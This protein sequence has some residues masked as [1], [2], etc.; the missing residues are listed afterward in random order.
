MAKPIDVDIA[1]T[2]LRA[3][4]ELRVHLSAFRGQQYLH[5]RR[6]YLDG[7]V[8]RPGKGLAVRIDML[9]WLMH[10]LSLALEA[11]MEAGLME[12]E[13]WTAHGLEPPVELLE[14]EADA[15]EEAAA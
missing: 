15:G 1:T 13:D 12:L 11:G 5:T 3:G 10:A 8:W 2:P 6:W 7:E 9:P 14:P 4:E